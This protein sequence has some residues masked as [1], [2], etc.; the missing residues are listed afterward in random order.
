MGSEF[1]PKEFYALTKTYWLI[2]C[3]RESKPLPMYVYVSLVCLVLTQLV[4]VLRSSETGIT[5]T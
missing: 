5:G 1:L 2:N 4:E 3:T